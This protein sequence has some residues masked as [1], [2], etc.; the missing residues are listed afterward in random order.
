MTEG[1]SETYYQEFGIILVSQHLNIG[2]GDVS[3]LLGTQLTHDVVVL[4]LCGDCSSLSILLQSSEDVCVA[5][6]SGD[7]PIAHLRLRVTLVWSVVALLLWSD[8]MRL[9]IVETFHGW[10]FPCCRTVGDKGIGEKDYG[11]EMLHGNL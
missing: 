11:S 5:L 6:L 9:D 7:C 10:Q 3:H 4:R 2:H 8:I 1:T